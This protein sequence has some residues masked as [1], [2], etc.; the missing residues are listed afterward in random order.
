M[1]AGAFDES[2]RAKEEGKKE[3]TVFYVSGGNCE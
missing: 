3:K 2:G 1:G